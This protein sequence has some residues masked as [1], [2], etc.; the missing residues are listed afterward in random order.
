MNILM[1][2]C[3]ISLS[4]RKWPDADLLHF[5]NFENGLVKVMYSQ[6]REEYKP[7]LT[8][9]EELE[10]TPF[11]IMVHFHQKSHSN[12]TTDVVSL[13]SLNKHNL[14]SERKPRHQPRSVL[15]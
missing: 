8:E 10:I 7:G 5:K 13:I 6:L 12:D 11:E 4:T 2:R 1:V 3:R 15:M 9:S 14:I